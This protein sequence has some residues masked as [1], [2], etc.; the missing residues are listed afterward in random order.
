MSKQIVGYPLGALFSPKDVRD[1]KLVATASNVDLPEEFKLP[2]VRIKNQGKIG[3]C[4]AHSL[5]EVVEYFNKQQHN[6]NYVMSTDFIYGNRRTSDYK[7]DGMVVRDALKAV[8]KYGD[9]RATKMSTNSEAPK[10]IET[11][12]ANYETL[13]DEAYRSRISAYVR[14]VTPAEV[15]EF[16]FSHGP[17]VISMEWYSDFHVDAQ[18]FL[19]STYDKDA[20]KGGHCMVLY[21]WTKEGWLIQNSWG[22]N[23]GTKGTCILPY[24]HTEKIREMWGVTDE[25]EDNPDDET[26]KKPLDS[27][28]GQFL[29]AI[30]NWILNLFSSS[31]TQQGE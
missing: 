29:A 22:T 5:S 23:W 19:T 14:L 17:V 3:S 21:G 10:A 31:N 16:L 28:F 18:G 11:F 8:Q 12:E 25:I 27:P 20:V 24:E 6:V 9:I 26:I 15:K 2:M 4:V 1:Y 13:K 30:L 7:G